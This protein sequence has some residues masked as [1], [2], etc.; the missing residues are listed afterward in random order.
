MSGEAW[1]FIP[2]I[3]IATLENSKRIPQVQVDLRKMGIKDYEFNFQTPPS[4][5]SH[6]S[7]TLSCTD[8]HLQIYRKALQKGYPYICVFEDDVF[9][10][11]L[12]RVKEVLLDIQNFIHRNEWDLIYLGHFPWKLGERV[13]KT[14]YQSVSWCTHAYLIS[15][16][17]MRYMTHFSPKTML[18]VGRLAVPTAF[19]LFFKEGGGIDTFLAYSTTRGKLK[20][21]AVSP[22]LIEQSSISQWSLKAKLVEKLSYGGWWTERVF[23]F[24]WVVYWVVVFIVISALRKKS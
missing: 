24:G 20:S 3:Y 1:E 12:N 13:S 22:L 11:D 7:A 2:R 16:R 10:N 14:L 21:F 5:K 18:D 8:N 4:V 23:Y 19:D 17:A 9:I 6:E 15:Q